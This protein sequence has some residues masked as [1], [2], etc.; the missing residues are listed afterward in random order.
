[1]NNNTE[2]DSNSLPTADAGT[3][4]NPPVNVATTTANADVA[5]GNLSPVRA[6]TA[7]ADT[8]TGCSQ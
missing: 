3:A 8:G 4:S 6:A 2:K 1:M 5:T 7:T